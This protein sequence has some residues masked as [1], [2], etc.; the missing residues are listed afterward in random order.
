MHDAASR[1]TPGLWTGQLQRDIR[2][3]S[4]L[5]GQWSVGDRAG[6]LS[7][8]KE[9]TLWFPGRA[10]TRTQAVGRLGRQTGRDPGEQREVW[11]WTPG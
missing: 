10:S 11:R 6:F 3:A 9:L 8:Q 1:Q 7:V 4:S 2:E 5:A